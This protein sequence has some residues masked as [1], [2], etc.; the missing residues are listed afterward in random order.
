MA[1]TVPDGLKISNVT[2]DGATLSWSPSA[3]EGGLFGYNLTVT[4]PEGKATAYFVQ[5]G[6]STILLIPKEGGNG[7]S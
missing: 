4:D 1:P 7:E 5:D 3:D 6:E 2:F